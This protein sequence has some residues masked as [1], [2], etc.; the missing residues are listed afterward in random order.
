MAAYNKGLEDVI[1]GESKLGFIDGS[2]GLLAYCGYPVEVLAKDSSFLETS[3]LLLNSILPNKNQLQEFDKAL[4]EKRELPK[5]ILDIISKFPPNTHPMVSLQAIV[6]LLGAFTDDPAAEK[7]TPLLLLV[8]IETKQLYL[9]S[10][11]ILRD[12]SIL[13][14]LPILRFRSFDKFDHRDEPALLF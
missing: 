12:N 13:F 11:K 14:F 4:R 9:R 6:A 5:N 3:Y 2:K 10:R 1:A 8:H 7:K